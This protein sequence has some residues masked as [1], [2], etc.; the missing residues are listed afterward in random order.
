MNSEKEIVHILP[1]RFRITKK[2]KGKKVS[3]QSI[4]D[5]IGVSLRQF[6][7]Y[8]NGKRPVPNDMLMCIC[9]KLDCSAYWLTG[10]SNHDTGFTTDDEKALAALMPA[11][12]LKIAL[13]DY[14][15]ES[16]KQSLNPN[17][18]YVQIRGKRIARSD[19]EILLKKLVAIIDF[20]VDQMI[21]MIPEKEIEPI[22]AEPDLQQRPSDTDFWSSLF[23]LP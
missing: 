11:Y 20:S 18:E 13:S 23:D 2:R 4:A 21:D 14:I 19:H 7:N 15:A 10:K 1:E 17:R 6:Q 5:E 8:V 22:E 9:S 16:S 3:N 12:T